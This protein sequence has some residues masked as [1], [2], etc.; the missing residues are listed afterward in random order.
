MIESLKKNSLHTELLQNYRGRT[1]LLHKKRVFMEVSECDISKKYVKMILPLT[2]EKSIMP[3]IEYFDDKDRREKQKRIESDSSLFYDKCKAYLYKVDPGD[4]NYYSM[5]CAINSDIKNEID[6]N[7]G[8]K[9]TY[10]IIADSFEEKEENEEALKIATAAVYMI[11]R[12]KKI[13]LDIGCSL[14]DAIYTDLGECV[15][16]DMSTEVIGFLK[17]YE[18]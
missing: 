13:N 7:Q 18:V 1:E 4:F 11:C 9:C 14:E 16:I 3:G 10:S 8:I 2:D 12:E 5:L 15:G 17:G 6:L